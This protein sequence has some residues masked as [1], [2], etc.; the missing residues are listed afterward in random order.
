MTGI[1]N[2]RQPGA[3]DALTW[4]EIDLPPPASG[5]VR[6]RHTAVGVNF[7]DVYHRSG[8]YPL[9]YPAVIG[10]EAAGVI[11]AVGPDVVGWEAGRRVAWTGQTGGYAQA[12]NIAAAWLVAI[13]EGVSD[14]ASGGGLLRGVTAHM[15]MDA[16]WVL[17]AGQTALIHSAAGGLGQLLVKWAKRRGATVIGTV[18]SPE[19]EE[20]ARAAGAH[21]V[22]RYREDDFVAATLAITDGRG[23]DVA[24]D[25]IGGDVLHRSLETVKPFGM[26][27]SVGQAGG[28]I[29]PFTIADLGPKRSIALARP[30][31]FAYTADLARYHTAAD[32]AMGAMADGL[33]VPI[34]AS[35]PL[36]DAAQAHRK[37]EAGKTTGALL[38]VP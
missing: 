20:T 14:A 37:L 7:V 11:E 6:V 28:A 3:A 17:K 4:E 10:V 35:Y 19:K 38:L 23:V 30:S 1:V 31:A 12:R 32:A 9:P 18:G 5:E 36:A 21:H 25:G 2:L 24:Y 22:I 29:P 13:P 16:V 34:S 8:L 15:L 33:T 26:V 27:V